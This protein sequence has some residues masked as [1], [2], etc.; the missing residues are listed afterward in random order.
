MRTMTA[1]LVSLILV[2]SVGTALTWEASYTFDE[3][4]TELNRVAISQDGGAKGKGFVD[5]EQTYIASFVFY[6]KGHNDI[7]WEF[8][9]LNWSK[10]L[11]IE[12]FKLKS[13]G[14]HVFYAHVRGYKIVG[15]Y[16][17]NYLEY[18]HEFELPKEHAFGVEESITAQLDRLTDSTLSG[19]DANAACLKFIE[20]KI[21]E[22]GTDGDTKPEPKGDQ[23]PSSIT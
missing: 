3:L 19:M 21:K 10:D 14:Y 8:G 16:W 1:L 17:I 20:E 22:G 23:R 12:V 15:E 18:F 9:V 6:H 2:F 4:V 11:C 7:E 5:V 13:G